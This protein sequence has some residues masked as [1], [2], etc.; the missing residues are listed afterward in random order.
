MNATMQPGAVCASLNDGHLYI[1]ETIG[2]DCVFVRP[3]A[4]G[5]IQLMPADDLWP[6]MDS[7]P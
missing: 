6:L 1:V 3:I 4:G 7:L 5:Q 2:A